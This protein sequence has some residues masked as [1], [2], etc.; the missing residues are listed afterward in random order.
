MAADA[1]GAMMFWTLVLRRPRQVSRLTVARDLADHAAESVAVMRI[2]G[3]S[4]SSP[5]LWH[6]QRTLSAR[7][8]HA[9]LTRPECGTEHLTTIDMLCARDRK[10]AAD[11]R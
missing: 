5:T 8:L 9:C 1:A 10:G 4:L 2:L 7:I 11:H 3:Q 6:A